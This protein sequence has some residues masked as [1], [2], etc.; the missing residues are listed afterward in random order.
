ME[1]L[2]IVSVERVERIVDLPKIRWRTEKG[3]RV[4]RDTGI[5]S[6]GRVVAIDEH[7]GELAFLRAGEWESN[8]PRDDSGNPM[9]G[10]HVP[11]T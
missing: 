7:C 6:Q 3:W 1:E 4:G 9:G 11:S 8:Y 2:P 10:D 5:E